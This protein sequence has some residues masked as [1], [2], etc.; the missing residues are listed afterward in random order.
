M[1]PLLLAAVE[2]STQFVSPIETYFG[3]IVLGLMLCIGYVVVR[4]YGGK[5]RKAEVRSLEESLRE[6]ELDA[7]AKRR[8]APEEEF[9]PLAALTPE[10]EVEMAR[11]RRLAKEQEKQDGEKEST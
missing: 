3:F 5:R 7:Y 2:P 4:T 8:R 11:A 10:Q 9:A 6:A 1:M